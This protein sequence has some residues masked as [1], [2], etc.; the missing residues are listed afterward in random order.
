[1][2]ASFLDYSTRHL[3]SVINLMD[4]GKLIV[5]ADPHLLN[6]EGFPVF[7]EKLRT[8]LLPVPQRQFTVRL[9]SA[10]PGGVSTGAALFALHRALEERLASRLY[11]EGKAIRT[12]RR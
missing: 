12:V 11:P 6:A 7:E 3:A 9:S 5:A 1:T 2:S 4:V 10:G 8:R